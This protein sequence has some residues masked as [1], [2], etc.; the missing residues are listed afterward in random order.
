MNVSAWVAV[1]CALVAIGCAV[2]TRRWARQAEQA[3]RAVRAM[4][5][6]E[7]LIESTR[8]LTDDEW[9][10]FRKNWEADH[11]RFAGR[12]GSQFQLIDVTGL[13]KLPKSEHILGRQLTDPDTVTFPDGVTVTRER[14][15]GPAPVI[16]I[17]MPT[18]DEFQAWTF[19]LKDQAGTIVTR[20]VAYLPKTPPPPPAAD[21]EVSD[22]VLIDLLGL[23][24]VTVTEQQVA[25]WT[26]EQREQA[27]N[28]AAAVHLA[29]SDND[30]PIS[31]RPEFLP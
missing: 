8:E 4:Q 20:S 5:M 18:N 23:V 10:Q 26:H 17:P 12:V 22:E 21:M 25:E 19:T 2:L 6:P 14:I 27:A 31:P 1:G 30:V 29:A 9:Q 11:G 7:G 16:G 28:W 13:G 15:P 24:C 3:V